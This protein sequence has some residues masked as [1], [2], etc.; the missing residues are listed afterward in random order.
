M[1]VPTLLLTI[2]LDVFFMTIG[3]DS[4]IP[5]YEYKGVW[6]YV[7]LSLS[8][9]TDHWFIAEDAFSHGGWWSL[10][11]EVWCYIAFAAAFYTSGWRRWLA[12]ILVLLVIGPKL[13]ALLLCW[14]MGSLVYRLHGRAQLT[15]GLATT[16][17][18]ATV[19][20]VVIAMQREAFL[21]IDHWAD[22]VSVGWLTTNMRF[23]QWFVGDVL[24]ASLFAASV[25][26]VKFAP[27]N[28]GVCAWT[29]KYLAS[30]TFTFYMVHGIILKL[31]IK[32]FDLGMIPTTAVVMAFTFVFASATE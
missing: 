21:G 23:S 5:L 9:T 26:A 10:S 18:I 11:Y 15:P 3:D 30:F 20:A 14:L 25:F 32:F 2:V 8:F 7:L 12:T 13:W 28:F 16:I 29:I 17:L 27:L 22:A 19:S 1:A 6:K 24:L 31:C 4:G